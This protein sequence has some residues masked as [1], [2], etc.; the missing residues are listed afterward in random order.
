MN[1]SNQKSEVKSDKKQQ[2][3]LLCVDDESSILKS[4]V[5]LFRGENFRVLTANSSHAAFELL[6][7]ETVQLVMVD[8]RMPDMSGTQFLL[9]VKNKHPEIVRVILS[10]Y[11]EASAM[12]EAINRGEVYRFLC[13]PW[14][15]DELKT[16]IRQCFEHHAL[17]DDNRK[18]LTQLQ[19]RNETLKILN[20]RLQAMVELR[21]KTLEINQNVIEHLPVPLLG[22]STDGL[23]VV[24]NALVMERVRNIVLGESIEGVFSLTTY[25]QIQHHLSSSAHE[26]CTDTP[27][28][29]VTTAYCNKTQCQLQIVPLHYENQLHGCFII[30]STDEQCK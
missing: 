2:K 6:K 7:K 30:L 17:V 9:Q 4:L 24:V 21:T 8:Q 1:A 18:L 23:V 29:A 14:E 28:T 22:V 11:S 26:S 16:T 10:G 15:N 12:L 25:R 19:Q 5:R 3:T 13:K 20:E 27:D